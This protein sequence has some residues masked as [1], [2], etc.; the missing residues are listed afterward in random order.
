MP[1]SVSRR[2]HPKQ[3]TKRKIDM[4]KHVFCFTECAYGDEL[5]PEENNECIA[6]FAIM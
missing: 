6:L 2:P 5:M 3:K 4:S 1:A